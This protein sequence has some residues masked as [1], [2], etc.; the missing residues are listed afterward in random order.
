MKQGKG[1]GVM[2]E[3]WSGSLAEEVTSEQRPEC[4]EGG[5]GRPAG[6]SKFPQREHYVQSSPRKQHTQHGQE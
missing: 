6:G 4:H 2:V 3:G 5:A 1:L